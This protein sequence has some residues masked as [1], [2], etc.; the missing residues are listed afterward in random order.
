[1]APRKL[2]DID[3]PPVV[4]VY[5]PDR[6]TEGL[7]A[8]LADRTDYRI[9]PEQDA[10]VVRDRLGERPAVDCLWIAA[11][12]DDDPALDL[13]DDA[14]SAD[15][16]THVLYAPDGGDVGLAAAATDRG[17]AEVVDPDASVE[18]RVKRV[19]AAV[20]RA[21][22][23][24][25]DAVHRSALETILADLDADLFVKDGR[26]RHLLYAP[27]ITTV[28]GEPLYGRTD[29]EAFLTSD[30]THQHAYEDDMAV[31]ESG[32]PILG[33]IERYPEFKGGWQYTSRVP[34]TEDGEVRG[35]VGFTLDVSEWKNRERELLQRVA[36]LQRIP[37]YLT[38]DLRNPLAIAQGYVGEAAGGDDL[39]LDVVED[40]LDRLDRRLDEFRTFVDVTVDPDASRV[41]VELVP[42]IEQLWAHVSLPGAE[43]ELHVPP[44]T[45]VIADEQQ[46]RPLFEN[47]FRNAIDHAGPS[48]T[49]R[50]Q[51]HE[52]GFSVCDDGPGLGPEAE[53]ILKEGTAPS[54]GGEKRLGLSI[55]REVCELHN[56]TVEPGESPLGG[57]E[58]R[59]RGPMV[60][61][62]IDA[63]PADGDALAVSTAGDVGDV[64]HAGSVEHDG[65][66]IELSG[67]GDNVWGWVNQ[68]QFYSAAVEGP[69]R[70]TARVA[71]LDV[72]SQY[73]K[74][75]VLVRS[76]RE[77]DA[78][79]AGV[80]RIE[81][82]YPELLWRETA[83]E[84]GYSYQLDGV[85]EAVRWLRV[86]R[87]GRTV[88]CSISRDGEEWAP[89]DRRQIALDEPV[90]VGLFA[91]STVPGEPITARFEDV[92]LERLE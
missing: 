35:L 46:L 4:L 86:D 41:P 40:A 88:V 58:L 7:A 87:R 55:V 84:R 77:A 10:A 79:Y 15:P 9:E 89:V 24:R 72:A 38:H 17:A 34:W 23:R 59:F 68:F 69:V 33:Q 20:D 29:P 22:R 47:L 25:R 6:R 42:L 81:D 52:D 56:W 27:D 21:I 31:V 80:G 30:E 53:R 43:L 12:A 83:G 54:E 67:A 39:A 78:A 1:M 60:A 13:V 90:H 61:T 74:A 19:E 92:S 64:Q 57:A 70:L 75:G 76:R 66:A 62:P 11:A 36:Q 48:V 8:A 49:V 63:V 65:D 51:L 37:K 85:D 45:H 18:D 32:D 50:V 44:G 91:C 82:R 3:D 73:S 5:G 28:E 16:M 2:W 14:A 26:A 71:D